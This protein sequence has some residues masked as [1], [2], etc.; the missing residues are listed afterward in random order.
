MADWDPER[1][2]QWFETPLGR[3]VEADEKALVFGLADL[4]TGQDVLD[5]GCGDG[6]YTVPAVER[7]GRAVGID[8]SDAMLRAARQRAESSHGA[9]YVVGTGEDLPFAD[10]TFD[11]VLMVTVLCFVAHPARLISEARRVLR[12]G[13][14]LIVGELGRH[15]I[16]AIVRRTRGMFGDPIWS[17][18][19]FY[20]PKDLIALLN[21]AGFEQS[22][23]QGAVFYPPVRRSSLLGAMRPI[24]SAGR[25][26]CPWAGAFLV[27]RGF[28]RIDP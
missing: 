7:T 18:A 2:R 26:L 5:V 6:S 8:P 11:A 4:K 20:S 24:E 15:S 1:Y 25:W 17:Q 9:L 10:A 23:V 12:P 19:R 28:K 27:A 16:W 21:G 13:G 3:T 14:R 22:V